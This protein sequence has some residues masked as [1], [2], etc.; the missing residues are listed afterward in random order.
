VNFET[1]TTTRV[2]PVA[3]A[4]APL[5]TSD[6]RAPRPP[7]RRQCCTIPACESV[8]ARKAPMAN[9]GIRRSVTPPNTTKSAPAIKDKSTIPCENTRRLPRT[10]NDPG[11]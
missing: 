10:L 11:R 9:S 2:I 5:T 8:N 3:T 4:P 7:C 6:A 1:A